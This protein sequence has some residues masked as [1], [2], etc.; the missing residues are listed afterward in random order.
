MM[1]NKLIFPWCLVAYETALYLSNDAYLPA[2]PQ[3]ATDLATTHY[4][5]QLT[6]AVFCLGMFVMQLSLAPFA[7]RYGRRPILLMGGVVFLV[8]TLICAFSHTITTLLLG[9]FFQGSAISSM[10]IAGYATIHELFDQEEAIHT[11]AR[12]SSITIVAP[13]FGPFLGSLV[14]CFAS[15]RWTFGI[16]WIWGALAVL[17]LYLKMPETHVSTPDNQSVNL[18]RLGGQY[19]RILTK[20]NFLKYCLPNNFLFAGMIAWIA[21][22]PFLVITTFHYS[23]VYF[24][25]FQVI[26]F[27]GFI[28]GTSLVKKLMKFMQ[29]HIL[30]YV[31]LGFTGVGGVLGMMIGIFAPQN[32]MAMI[33]AL[34]FLTFG[35]GLCLPILGRFAVEAVPEEP[36]GVRMSV[37]SSLS[38][39][40]ITLSAAFAAGVSQGKLLNFA[41]VILFYVALAFAC[42]FGC[43]G[44]ARTGVTLSSRGHTPK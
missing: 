12:M 28:I 4:L 16:L 34:F 35:S 13:A 17:M 18:R 31:G 32:L 5:A 1:K 42:H 44:A 36:M 27:G 25:V 10:M 33:A 19:F 30:I 21:V 2:L 7:D 15:W 20:V 41:G 43:R 8:A 29:M 39:L 24:G 14:L 40:M 23:P 38:S 6:L 3:V 37:S 9:R 26:V 11:L 22:G